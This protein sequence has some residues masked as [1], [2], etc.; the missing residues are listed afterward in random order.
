MLI[1]DPVAD[2]LIRI[3]NGYL[4]S[5]SEVV[6]PYSAFKYEIVK[7]LKQ[8]KFIEDLK[9]TEHQ[10]KPVL[11]VHLYDKKKKKF[12]DL[13][14]ISKPGCRVYVGKKKIPYVREGYGICLISTPKGV[15]T[16]EEARRKGLGG[17]LLAEV[18]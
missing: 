16:G 14:Q 7:V 18:W 2:T 3:K 13:R 11:R 1:T 6:I 15:M 8:F 5:K 17:E 10:G 4:A 12:T 9:K